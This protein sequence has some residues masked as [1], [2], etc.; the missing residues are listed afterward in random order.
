VRG[1]VADKESR[2]GSGCATRHDGR[3][4]YRSEGETV[5]GEMICW[6]VV[7]VR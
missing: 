2:G 7:Y 1:L 5:H 6:F 3:A 4:G